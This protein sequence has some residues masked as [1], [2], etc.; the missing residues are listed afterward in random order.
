[1]DEY[2]DRAYGELI[3]DKT[4]L[5]DPD[6]SH[7]RRAVVVQLERDGW[8][9]FHIDVALNQID[10]AQLGFVLAVARRY[11]LDA[12]EEAGWLRLSRHYNDSDGEEA[13]EPDRE[14]VA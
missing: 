10:A 3:E 4:V 6:E 12:R 14:A 13:E 8:G 11:E 2:I 5:Y 9:D 1:M 7:S